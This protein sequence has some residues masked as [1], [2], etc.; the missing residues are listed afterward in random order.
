VLF[1]PMLSRP[2]TVA[3]RT[4]LTAI[5]QCIIERAHSLLFQHMPQTGHG[6]LRWRKGVSR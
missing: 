1:P 6:F 4:P 5:G 3:L 2:D